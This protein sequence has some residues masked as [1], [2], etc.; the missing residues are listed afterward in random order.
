MKSKL[1]NKKISKIILHQNDTIF[2]A[3]RKLNRSKLQ[4]CL[5]LDKKLKLLGTITDGDIRRAIIK[6]IEFK[7]SVSKI[8]NKK[9][10]IIRENF[11]INSA[12]NLMQKK[13]SITTSSN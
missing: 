8:M 3:V 4:V 5:V 11:D 10:I 7:N 13:K 12:K 9:P 6:K 2:D 1:K